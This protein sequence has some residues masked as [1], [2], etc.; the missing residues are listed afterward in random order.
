MKTS[1]STTKSAP[2]PD[3]ST[4]DQIAIVAY[5]I[6]VQKGCQPGHELDDWLRAEELVKQSQRNGQHASG[7][8]ARLR[9]EGSPVSA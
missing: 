4:H 8:I 7:R 2:N 1:T 6:Y 9:R 3:A 5:D